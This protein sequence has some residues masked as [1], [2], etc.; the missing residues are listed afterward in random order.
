MNKSFT[1][2]ILFFIGLNLFL[3]SRKTTP[4]EDINWS[5]KMASKLVGLVSGHEF[6]I[7]AME[8]LFWPIGIDDFRVE[9]GGNE[10]LYPEE[11]L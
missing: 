6:S 5:I 1:L 11:F 7:L 8:K 10:P 4:E 9:R 2:T 3:C